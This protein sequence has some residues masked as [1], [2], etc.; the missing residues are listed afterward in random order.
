M[1]KTVWIDNLIKV[2]EYEKRLYGRLLDLSEEKTSAVIKGELENLQ[3][4][5]A[6][7]QELSDELKKLAD[8][9]EKI[10]GQIGKSI[11][12]YPDKITVND[13]IGLVPDEYSGRL[14]KLS[15]SLKET[16]SKLKNKNDLNSHLIKNALDYVEFSLNL[17]MQPVPQAVQ[18]GRKGNEEGSK[19]RGVL[20]IKY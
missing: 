17:L 15:K 20:D 6:K 2:L 14:S 7:E 5:T 1:I 18:Y 13:L 4:I 10:I 9:R 19:I 12:K 16:V 3:T 8:I 11:G